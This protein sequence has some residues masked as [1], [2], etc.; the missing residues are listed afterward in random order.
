MQRKTKSVI[1]FLEF[2]EQNPTP[3]Y[4]LKMQKQ[5]RKEQYPIIME[6]LN[7]DSLIQYEIKLMK[8]KATE[9]L[10]NSFWKTDLDWENNRVHITEVGRMMLNTASNENDITARLVV[11]NALEALRESL[12]FD[13]S[14]TIAAAYGAKEFIKAL[15][16]ISSIKAM[17]DELVRMNKRDSS[18]NM[19]II[20][21]IRDAKHKG[22]IEKLIQIIAGVLAFQL[23]GSLKDVM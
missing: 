7:D 5:S 15:R 21:K 23:S 16:N 20:A 22:D 14:R 18:K 13:G 6:R 4:V 1:S 2:I 10:K 9:Q 11:F 3:E 17:V 8:E 19:T 12:K